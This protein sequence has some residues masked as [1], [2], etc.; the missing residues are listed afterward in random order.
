MIRSPPLRLVRRPGQSEIG[1][2]PIASRPGFR[3][4]IMLEP[5]L[6]H[7]RNREAIPPQPIRL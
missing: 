2:Y 7:R 4:S 6:K 3:S 5:D 1:L